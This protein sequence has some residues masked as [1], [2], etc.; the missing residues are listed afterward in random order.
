[1]PIV[2]QHAPNRNT[3]RISA[4]VKGAILA[5]CPCIL[6]MTLACNHRAVTAAIPANTST[7]TEKLSM[8]PD[9]VNTEGWD[10]AWTNL[11]N[12]AEQ[13]FTPLLPKL[14]G[15][16]V[17]LIVGNPGNSEDELTLQ[18]LDSSGQTLA[19]VAQTVRPENC[20]HVMFVMP[21]G[22][23][24]LSPGRIYRLQ[25]TGGA[26]FGWKYVVGGYDHGEATLNGHP[27]L[28][29]ARSTFLFRTFGQK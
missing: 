7:P 27:L 10:K 8:Q 19:V 18:L 22:G 1:M 25:L 28:A 15:V 6:A 26:T 24:A 14:R 12:V 2:V 11:L 16:E 4:L 3:P 17:E 5:V 29:Q 20:D 21:A 9:Q 13:S 23:V